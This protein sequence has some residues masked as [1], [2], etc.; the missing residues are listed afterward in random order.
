MPYDPSFPPSHGELT[1]AA[2]RA[3]FNG[4]HDETASILSDVTV[5]AIPKKTGDG[6]LGD[7]V[8]A[9]DDAQVIL[10]GKLLSL[11]RPDTPDAP[12]FEIHNGSEVV[13]HIRTSA[14]GSRIYFSGNRPGFTFQ[15]PIDI[16]GAPVALKPTSVTPLTL[17][18]SDPM[19][20]SDGQA[21]IDKV[22]ELI[23]KLNE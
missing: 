2:Y 4:L 12:L 14:D 10:N 7:S 19:S 3:Q 20:A 13:F 22:N 23:A 18:P 1:S 16:A 9:E 21:V 17:T 6:T 5:G 15:T 8:L 11:R